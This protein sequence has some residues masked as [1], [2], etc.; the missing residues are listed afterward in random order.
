[1]GVV[2]PQC[3]LLPT[4]AILRSDSLQLRDLTLHLDIYNDT[5]HVRRTNRTPIPL[6]SPNPD[7]DLVL[8]ESQPPLFL[9]DVVDAGPVASAAPG[10]N[11]RYAGR[12]S[13]FLHHP[14]AVLPGLRCRPAVRSGESQGTGRRRSALQ[15]R[16]SRAGPAQSSSAGLVPLEHSPRRRHPGLGRGPLH[17]S[18]ARSLRAARHHDFAHA[19]RHRHGPCEG[20]FIP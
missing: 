4:S 12:P 6:F 8:D 3:H 16:E 17:A 14:V 10:R 1:M 13:P 11:R 20:L 7:H 9:P 2:H 18:P 5:H 19:V 15:G